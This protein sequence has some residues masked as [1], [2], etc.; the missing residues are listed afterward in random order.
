MN[1][2]YSIRYILQ[3][4][5]TNTPLEIEP[6]EHSPSICYLFQVFFSAVTHDRHYILM[7]LFQVSCTTEQSSSYTRSTIPRRGDITPTTFDSKSNK[8]PPLVATKSDT[9]FSTPRRASILT[10]ANARASS[11]E[12]FAS[13]AACTKMLIYDDDPITSN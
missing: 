11:L 3:R 7:V 4:L 9:S 5:G 6:R 12:R 2:D 13:R 1:A 10:E 8:S